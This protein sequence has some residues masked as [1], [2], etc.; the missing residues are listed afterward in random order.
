MT[1]NM[2]ITSPVGESFQIKKGEPLKN[3]LNLETLRNSALIVKSVYDSF[4]VEEFVDSVLDETWEGLELKARSR[5]VTLNLRKYLPQDYR[6]ALDILVKVAADYISGQFV[7]GF[8][9][10]DFVEVYGQDESN[11]DISINALEVFTTLWSSEMAVRPFIVKNEERMMAQMLAWSKHENEHIRRL[12]SEGCRPALPWAMALPAFKKDPTP[13]L[14]ILE[15]LKTDPSMYVRKSVANNLNDISKTRPDVVRKVAFDWYGENKHTDWI[16][17][18][19]CRSLLKKADEEILTLFGLNDDVNVS[20]EG[21]ALDANSVA[22]GNSLGFSFV[23]K[24]TDSAKARLEYAIDFVKSGGKT[25]R[26]IFK[27]SEIALKANEKRQYTKNH[28]FADL[29]TRKHYP[30]IH[31]ITII[32]NGV[33]KEKVDFEVK[34]KE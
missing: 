2:Q 10:P 1:D 28:S 19:G 21:F 22:I 8:S 30:G 20:V 11:W 15:Q 6:E 5:Q 18:H 34:E 33:E 12:S 23:L 25:S 27:I 26:K 32:V 31:T 7:I 17:K 9:F 4:P 14:P 13:I 16:V 24:S 3:M 29:S